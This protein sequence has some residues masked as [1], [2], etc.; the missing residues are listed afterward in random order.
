MLDTVS[1]RCGISHTAYS[2]TERPNHPVGSIKLGKSIRASAEASLRYAEDHR[3]H[4]LG[5]GF[6]S[7]SAKRA[8]RLI[9][10]LSP[11]VEATWR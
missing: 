2:N 4:W 8:L 1:Q 5:L 10:P 6:E 9:T 11:T 7:V 3:G